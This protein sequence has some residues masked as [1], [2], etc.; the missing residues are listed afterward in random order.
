[1]KEKEEGGKMTDEAPSL[2]VNRRLQQ[3]WCL[4]LGEENFSFYKKLTLF[5]L[6][7]H[8]PHSSSF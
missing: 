3:E 6:E 1:M 4:N 2:A 8:G 5:S 7:Q